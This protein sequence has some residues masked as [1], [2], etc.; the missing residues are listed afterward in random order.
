M[1]VYIPISPLALWIVH[2]YGFRVGIYL[3][4][5]LNFVGSL[6]RYV[7]VTNYSYVYIGTIICS[8]A[9]CFILSIPPFIASQWY[10]DT[11]RTTATSLGVM[12]NELG[13]AVGMGATTILHFQTISSNSL[14]TIKSFPIDTHSDLLS[15]ISHKSTQQDLYLL[16]DEA[17][18]Q[19]YI[20]LQMIISIIAM[21][22][23]FIFVTRDKP[24]TPPS[25][26]ATKANAH[27]KSKFQN[28]VDST[29]H[30]EL[31]QIPDANLSSPNPPSI[32]LMTLNSPTSTNNHNHTRSKQDHFMSEF[33][34]F[35]YSTSRLLLTIVY[36]ATVGVFYCLSTFLTQ[37][38]SSLYS[39]NIIGGLGLTLIL[40]GILGSYWSAYII[41]AILSNHDPTNPTNFHFQ[42][43]L[44]MFKRMNSSRRTI[45]NTSSSDNSNS[46][47][48]NIY[49]FMFQFL[50][51]GACV[52][53]IFLFLLL[54]LLQNHESIDEAILHANK[55]YIKISFFFL[56]GSTGFFLIGIISVG[57][58]YGSA[59]CYP[60]NEAAVG[61]AL[62]CSAQ[63]GGWILNS[64]GGVFID[65]LGSIISSDDDDKITND[66]KREM[67]WVVLKFGLMLVATLTIS[68]VIVF[69][70]VTEI[71]IRLS[72][73][74]TT[75][76]ERI[77]END[78]MPDKNISTR[79]N[80]MIV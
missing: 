46:H 10:G 36:G 63:L 6:L 71:P 48:W 74:T 28:E 5:I 7:H 62:N 17:T 1:I 56:V 11:E 19:N 33:F 49:W 23:I 15:E 60:A 76:N 3:G 52:T 69:L 41:D 16:Q 26:I 80:S 44:S 58:E 40:A 30:L 34:A 13:V 32:S 21:M 75:E 31:S 22:M 43:G 4:A 27:S 53:T 39:T 59:L 68:F 38:F 67:Q 47:G 55:L 64:I 72:N 78:E 29:I 70:G 8:V 9:Q 18:L 37:I 35:L 25:A 42:W 2:H 73:I 45:G 12:A 14:S 20:G 79:V 61:G 65:H 54:F 77:V 57:F 51:M 50:L 24:L 66:S